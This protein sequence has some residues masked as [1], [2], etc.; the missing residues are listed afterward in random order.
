V[1]TYAIKGY[2]ELQ[3]IAD[4]MARQDQR[5]AMARTIAQLYYTEARTEDT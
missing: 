5:Q 2:G 3:L 1:D 4:L